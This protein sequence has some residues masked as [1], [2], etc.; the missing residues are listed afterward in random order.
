MDTGTQ[1]AD[2]DTNR[3]SY[4]GTDSLLVTVVRCTT[5]PSYRSGG[6]EGRDIRWGSLRPSVVAY[7]GE[8]DVLTSQRS[9]EWVGGE[10]EGATRLRCP[11]QAAAR[12]V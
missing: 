9:G 12:R 2:D 4:E 1:G 8:H 10:R 5:R 11:S 3:H 6:R 7:V